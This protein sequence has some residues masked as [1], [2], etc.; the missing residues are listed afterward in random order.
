MFTLKKVENFL[1]KTKQK[2]PNDI[3]TLIINV[4]VYV[5]TKLV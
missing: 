4:V 1:L 5:C 3:Y 2:N